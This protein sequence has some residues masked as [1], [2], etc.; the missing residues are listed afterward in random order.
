AGAQELA[1]LVELRDTEFGEREAIAR[2]RDRWFERLGERACAIG[3]DE[4]GPT[5]EIARGAYGEGAGAQ[6]APLGEPRGRPARRH[7]RYEVER[8]YAPLL[9]DVA[10]GKAEAGETRHER[11]DDVEGGG[12][13][14]RCIEG[15]A[16]LRQ[17][18]CPGLGRER[19][20]G[21]Y[22]TVERCDGGSS[23]VHLSP[24][25]VG[26]QPRFY[27]PVARPTRPGDR[28]RCPARRSPAA[29]GPPSGRSLPAACRR[30]RRV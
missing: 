20:G 25:L 17:Q 24:P 6:L 13:G 27:P 9:G 7:R 19:V 26:S 22:N 15:I 21:G 23:A 28:S 30:I 12:C 1:V 16:S 18:P 3:A 5:R 2:Q 8:A 10:G 4:L 14:D 11:F 29:P